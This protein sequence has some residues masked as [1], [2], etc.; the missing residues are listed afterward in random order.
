MLGSCGQGAGSPALDGL[1]PTPDPDGSINWPEHYWLRRQNA[2]ND[3]VEAE[4]LGRA[5]WTKGT[6]WEPR[7]GEGM[8]VQHR[9][10]GAV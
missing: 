8:S 2:F 4:H 3:T 5:R 10:W 9:G 1:I 6:A 7:V